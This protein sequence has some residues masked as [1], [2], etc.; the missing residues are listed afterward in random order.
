MSSKRKACDSSTPKLTAETQPLYD[1]FSCLLQQKD[2]QIEALSAKLTTLT[3][4]VK[5]LEQKT[6]SSTGSSSPAANSKR[7]MRRHS[8]SSLLNTKSSSASRLPFMRQSSAGSLSSSSRQ[9]V[10]KLPDM[11]CEV[12][13]NG[14]RVVHPKPFLP[15]EDG[16]PQPDKTL[17]L[18]FVYGY[19]GI[20][21]RSNLFDLATGELVYLVDAIAVLFHVE[22][23]TQRFYTEHTEEIRCLAVHPDGVTMAT[24]D[25]LVN[26]NA[27]PE[28][29]VWSGKTLSTESCFGKGVFKKGVGSVAFSVSRP[30]L[31]ACV[32]ESNRH[33]VTIWKWASGTL[34][35]QAKGHDDGVFTAQFNPYTDV[36]VTCGVK[37]IHFW[38]VMQEEGSTAE[39]PFITLSKKP[40]LFQAHEKPRAL[41]CLT[42]APNGDTVTGD[43]NGNLLV[44]GPPIPSHVISRVLLRAHQGAIYSVKATSDGFVSGG[45]DNRVKLW[46]WDFEPFPVQE[47]ETAVME[48]P[49]AVRCIAPFTTPDGPSLSQ[50]MVGTFS[51]SIF[52]LDMG[53]GTS[54]LV[55]A[56]QKGETC[57]VVWNPT[58]PL[59]Y[60][61]S[62]DGNLCCWNAD[63]R[64]QVWRRN[65]V[66]EEDEPT[67]VS[68]R[69]GHGVDEHELALGLISGAVMIFSLEG[70]QKRI[71]KGKGGVTRL[72]YSPDGRILAVGCADGSLEVFN[73]ANN[74]TSISR[75]RQAHPQG[76]QWI[77]W[78][79]DAQLF[80]TMCGG[81]KL[82]FWIGQTLQP[83][84]VMDVQQKAW[85]TVSCP[86][87]SNH[88]SWSSS[89]TTCVNRYKDMLVSADST[90]SLALFSFPCHEGISL[91]QIKIHASPVLALQL[92][93]ATQHVCLISSSA[94]AC[95]LFQFQLSA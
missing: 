79:Q 11:M 23:H 15:P 73:C 53:D 63:K 34:L 47:G 5:T 77:D 85:E 31:L 20:R 84:A 83:A 67:C 4:R 78:T 74:Y 25:T 27:S 76:V 88:A 14:T 18:S 60:T 94:G 65:V 26:L 29:R 91:H 68:L 66:S 86:D 38:T 95:G 13:V 50:M 48:L 71:V 16:P 28:V 46:T 70:Q 32:D 24:G 92:G 10:S 40:G 9:T 80:R 30:Y 54:E 55:S 51:N 39:Q 52:S 93:A 49:E 69:L 61:V 21:S 81:G 17:S 33:T 1:Y 37:H 45:R 44:W 59:F 41:L 19:Q 35:A 6:T 82:K 72:V 36:L 62:T 8:S 43:S 2:E 3:A 89:G 87:W 57:D 22:E 12:E 56:G 58:M 90:G 7:L 64:E 42:F 75:C